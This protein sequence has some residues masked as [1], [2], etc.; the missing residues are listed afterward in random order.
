MEHRGSDRYDLPRKRRERIKRW[1]AEHHDWDA[2][3]MTAE[4][5]M[6]PEFAGMKPLVRNTVYKIM[7]QSW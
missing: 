2:E 3:R 5:N 1:M 7:T 4:I 6:D